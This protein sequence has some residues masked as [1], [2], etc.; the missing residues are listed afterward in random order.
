MSAGAFKGRCDSCGWTTRRSLRNM[1]QKPC[2]KCGGAVYVDEEDREQAILV[3]GIT[4]AAM[5][6]VGIFVAVVR[7]A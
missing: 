4:I 3:A 2:P 7:A 6:V 1:K 5:A